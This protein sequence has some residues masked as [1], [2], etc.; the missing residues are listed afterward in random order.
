[1]KWGSCLVK[2]LKFAE[3]RQCAG[4]GPWSHLWE[5]YMHRLDADAEKRWYVPFL[6]SCRIIQLPSQ[7]LL[8]VKSNSFKYAAA[9]HESFYHFW[10]LA[11][12]TNM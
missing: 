1:M 5:K 9:T 4:H 3:V 8:A 6:V 7:V 11:C 2:L 12:N 10:H